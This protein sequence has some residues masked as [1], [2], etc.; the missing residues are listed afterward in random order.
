MIGP[1]HQLLATHCANHRSTSLTL[2]RC[3]LVIKQGDGENMHMLLFLCIYLVYAS[4]CREL[5]QYM[6]GGIYQNIKMYISVIFLK[7]IRP[8]RTHTQMKSDSGTSLQEKGPGYFM[9]KRF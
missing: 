3:D 4:P 1:F 9:C 6:L 7:V 8:M 5:V 2:N